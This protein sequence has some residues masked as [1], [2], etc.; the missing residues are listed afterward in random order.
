MKEKIIKYKF[1][2]GEII[3]FLIALIPRLW[4]VFQTLPVRTIGDELGHIAGAVYLSSYDWSASIVDTQYYGQGF[5]I[6]FFWLFNLTDNPIII[7]HSI[8]AICCILQAMI[9]FI[10]FKICRNYAQ[11]NDIWAL[12]LIAVSSS[13]MIVTR[14][15]ILYNENILNVLIWLIFFVLCKMIYSK[16]VKEYIFSGACLCLLAGW[17]ITIHLRFA[18]CMIALFIVLVVYYIII[19]KKIKLFYVMMVTPVFGVIGYGFVNYIQNA[20]WLIEGSTEKLGNTTINLKSSV[21]LGEQAGIL[22]YGNIL[23]GQIS[24]I[25]I[26]SCAFFVLAAIT[27]GSYL[28]KNRRN[29]EDKFNSMIFIV[30]GML[31]LSIL[32]TAFAQSLTWGNGVY[33]GLENNIRDANYYSYKAFT[34]IRYFGPYVSS[35]IAIG[36]ILILKRMVDIGRCVKK[37]VIIVVCLVGYWMNFIQPYIS[38]NKHASEVF[39]FFSNTGGGKKIDES[40]YLFGILFA[41]LSS[42]LLLLLHKK[43]YT[44]YILLSIVLLWN[45]IYMAKGYD[46]YAQKS[47]YQKIDKTYDLL[48]DIPNLPEKIYYFYDKPIDL[49]H[50][51]Y[52]TNY[53]L[54]QFWMP[55]K[56]IV[57]L[58]EEFEVEEDAIILSN[59]I[60]VRDFVV[61][62]E[63]LFAKLDSGEYLFVFGEYMNNFQ[64]CLNKQGYNY[65][66]HKCD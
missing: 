38:E 60:D 8:L 4:I 28:W 65:K 30:G 24:T 49:Y 55:R 23:L 51:T 62:K 6:F 46:I 32:G 47:N 45:Y 3:C 42:V 39:L 18:V 36:S 25:T 44:I 13:Y 50:K 26:F 34:Y 19:R 41:L 31:I 29:L 10:I 5:Y 43:T 56:Q 14:V 66:I 40:V 57:P 37:T 54:L 15:S 21:N 52:A 12:S 17:G 22:T 11:I 1:E 20:V 48:Q 53:L 7:Y 2:L 63:Y 64:N 27:F 61:D 59:V 9:I 16:D 35:F 33:K 58:K